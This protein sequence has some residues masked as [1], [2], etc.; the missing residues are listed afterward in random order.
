MMRF[1]AFRPRQHEIRALLALAELLPANGGSILEQ[2]ISELNFWSRQCRNLM[3]WTWRIEGLK[4]VPLPDR[5]LFPLNDDETIHPL[6]AVTM[7]RRGANSGP[8]LRTEVYF[9]AGRI[10]ELIFDKS[11]KAVFGTNK[12]EDADI[13]VVDA[14][15]VVDPTD[16]GAVSH[17][18]LDSPD[19]LTGWVR[20]WVEKWG[21]TRLR[22][23][24]NDALRQRLISF[25][26]VVLPQ[27]YL[28]LVSQLE[29][30]T[31]KT[32]SING[33]SEL[34]GFVT[35]SESYY[36]LAMADPT[37]LF[38]LVRGAPPGI[39]YIDFEGN[40]PIPVGDSLVSAVEIFLEHGN[41]L[42]QDKPGLWTK[43]KRK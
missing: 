13:E 11:P 36:A 17:E 27:D 21:A 18:L 1:G 6:G 28:E 5:L 19:Q 10:F 26:D 2:Q 40:E 39:Y 30:I 25:Y 41:T 32:C 34:D 4:A 33:L 3:I 23:P 24:V 20:D 14:T 16:P 9:V 31:I 37:G 7:R 43:P 29:G 22:K 38:A 35:P 12:P 8:S 42:W 15:I